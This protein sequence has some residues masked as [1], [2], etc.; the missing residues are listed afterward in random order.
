MQ[1]LAS[2][3]KI[4]SNINQIARSLNRMKMW[5][6]TTKGMF[7]ELTKIQEGVNTIAALF[8]EKK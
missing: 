5:N 8:K 6:D 7:Q 2:L 4:G 1:L 3:G